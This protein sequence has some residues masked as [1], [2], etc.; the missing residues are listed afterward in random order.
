MILQRRSERL[1]F[2]ELLRCVAPREGLDVLAHVV[3]GV[4]R[5]IQT[6]PIL[7]ELFDASPER[8]EL[9]IGEKR[10]A[11]DVELVLHGA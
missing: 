3:D 1:I 9:R 5:R 4:D 11:Q 2:L 10:P 8:F 6:V 7:P